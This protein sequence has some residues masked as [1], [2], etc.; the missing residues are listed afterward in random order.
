M[1]VIYL[2]FEDFWPFVDINLLFRT[3]SWEMESNKMLTF[4]F[5]HVF[6][7]SSF[8]ETTE[9]IINFVF[10]WFDFSCSDTI[11]WVVEH[12]VFANSMIHIYIMVTE[13][14][15]NALS[16]RMWLLLCRLICHRNSKNWM[17]FPGL[18][19]PVPFRHASI[20]QLEKLTNHRIM[21]CIL[22]KISECTH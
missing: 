7:Y 15:H 16:L 14:V 19:G 11:C 1:S 2:L 17:N 21:Q 3:S 22:P 12:A 13:R 8:S 20:L 6:L 5:R 4:G 10:L 9:T 18:Y